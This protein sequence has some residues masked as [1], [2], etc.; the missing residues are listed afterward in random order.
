MPAEGSRLKVEYGTRQE[1]DNYVA[2]SGHP[3]PS[4]IYYLTDTRQIIIDGDSYSKNPNTLVYAGQVNSPD[5]VEPLQ[6]KDYRDTQFIYS[7][8]DSYKL[9]LVSQDHTTPV[10]LNKILDGSIDFSQVNFVVSTIST[11]NRLEDKVPSVKALIDYVVKYTEDY[12]NSQK[13]I[14]NG[15]V[16]LN[17]EGK[18]SSEQYEYEVINGDAAYGSDHDKDRTDL[19]W[20][21]E[22]DLPVTGSRLNKLL[23]DRVAKEPHRDLSTNDFD[24]IYKTMLDTLSTTS[25]TSSTAVFWGD[26]DATGTSIKG[27][28]IVYDGYTKSEAVVSD[29]GGLLDAKSTLERLEKFTNNFKATESFNI[30]DQVSAKIPSSRMIVDNINDLLST[31]LVLENQYTLPKSYY[32]FEYLVLELSLVDREYNETEVKMKVYGSQVNELSVKISDSLFVQIS[33]EV[34]PATETE[35]SLKITV[36]SYPLD[37]GA[38]DMDTQLEQVEVRDEVINVSQAGV[39][40][41]TLNH[42]SIVSSTLSISK[43]DGTFREDVTLTDSSTGEISTSSEEG[44]SYKQ[45]DESYR[46]KATYSYYKFSD[47]Q[48][49]SFAQD[50]VRTLKLLDIKGGHPLS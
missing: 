12:V 26:K 18:I 15:I 19:R 3:D 17:S 28:P 32:S 5:D 2:L 39:V 48:L 31:E 49:V 41:Y 1:Y 16:G 13:N 35:V 6:G 27:R 20:S 42:Q 33:A 30:T 8:G 10:E 36:T 29:P 46:D 22:K 7:V 9:Y 37:N 23:S 25:T 38:V 45:N 34:T 50:K 14:E 4:V 47:E 24:N 44:F 43:P 40:D 11:G 21:S